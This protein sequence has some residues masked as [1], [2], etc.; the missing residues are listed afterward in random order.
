MAHLAGGVPSVSTPGCARRSGGGSS[1]DFFLT[2]RDRGPFPRD[3]AWIRPENPRLVSFQMLRKNNPWIFPAWT[4]RPGIGPGSRAAK[5]AL[6]RARAR[7]ALAY[8]AR[9]RS[10]SP[11]A[12]FCP[13]SCTRPPPIG[14]QGSAL[15]VFFWPLH[16]DT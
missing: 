6:I 8:Q 15:Q 12:Q 3:P 11:P 1:E 2:S 7:H 14:S 13:P 9:C 5:G 16:L 4:S 10:S